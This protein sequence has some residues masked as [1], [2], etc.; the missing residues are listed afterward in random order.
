MPS[1][2]LEEYIIVICVDKMSFIWQKMGM[3]RAG[4]PQRGFIN[5]KFPVVE[6]GS[7]YCSS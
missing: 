4:E 6:V 7:L 2:E 3:G 5:N 1:Q